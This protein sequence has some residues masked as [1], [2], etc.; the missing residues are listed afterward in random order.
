MMQGVIFIEHSWSTSNNCQRQ[1]KNNPSKLLDQHLLVFYLFQFEVEMYKKKCCRL[2]LVTWEKV[3]NLK[4]LNEIL[5]TSN[6]IALF[7]LCVWFTYQ[8]CRHVS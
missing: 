2:K 1:N 6:T 5:N 7:K 4:H 8:L 3:N